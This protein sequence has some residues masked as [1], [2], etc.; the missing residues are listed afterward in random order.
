MSG[1]VSYTMVPWSYADI[2]CKLKYLLIYLCM[3]GGNMGR[4]RILDRK[5]IC[6]IFGET[7]GK[8]L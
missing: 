3:L 6:D 4:R 8:I 5:I 1:L 7:D 2:D